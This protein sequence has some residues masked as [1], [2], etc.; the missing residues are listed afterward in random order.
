MPRGLTAGQKTAIAAR[1]KV[2]IYFARL[3]FLS[4]TERV[5]TG[6]GDVVALGA[7]WKGLGEFGIINGLETDRTLKAGSISLALAGLPGASIA[8]GAIAASRSQRYQG[9]PVTIYFGVG[10]PDTLALLADPSAI[11]SG[12]ADVVSFAVG[13]T[14]TA[15]LTCENYSSHMRRSNGRRMTTES[16]NQGLGNPTPRDLFFDPADRLM[17]QARPLLEA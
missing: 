11:W 10:D 14:V 15:E 1:V 7:T 6:V 16:H 12:V 4:G 13:E 5:W 8:A 3:D 2:P 9:R 17:G